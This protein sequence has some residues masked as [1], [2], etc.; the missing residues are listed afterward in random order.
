MG[1][2]L[3]YTSWEKV[4]KAAEAS[5]LE[6]AQ[7]RAAARPLAKAAASM[8]RWAPSDPFEHVKRALAKQRAKRE[9]AKLTP[10][11]ATPPKA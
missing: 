2:K 3:K 1:I 11:E 4:A 7:K 5:D 9:A 6:L 8:P 10:A